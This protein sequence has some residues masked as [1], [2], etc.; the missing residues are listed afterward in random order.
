MPE[1]VSFTHE[2]G[3]YRQVSQVASPTVCRCCEEPAG[4][5]PA[6][7]R[8]EGSRRDLVR[9]AVVDAIHIE[10]QG[11]QIRVT[12]LGIRVVDQ[13]TSTVH[14][15]KEKIFRRHRAIREPLVSANV[16]HTI[17]TYEHRS[18]SP[19]SYAQA[20]RREQR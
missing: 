4:N 1:Q 3:R 6:D 16:S 7:A 11:N 9:G 13:P 17:D 10:A 15:H 2:A 14:I 20:S 12:S 18:S 19:S 8:V 5:P